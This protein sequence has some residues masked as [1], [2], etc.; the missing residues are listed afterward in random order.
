MSHRFSALLLYSVILLQCGI[1]FAQST[2][3]IGGDFNLL[4]THFSG[5]N[6]A[7][8]EFTANRV[9]SSYSKL[10]I[11]GTEDLGNGNSAIF[12]IQTNFRGDT[13]VAT[14]CGLECWVGL[15]GNWGV[16]KLG[17]MVPIYDD[18]S[19]PWYFTDTPGNHNPNAL[20]ANCGNG[21]GLQDG[22]MNNYLSRT[23]RYDSPKIH[24]VTLGVSYSMPP[25]EISSAK[26]NGKILVLGGKVEYGN[27]QLGFAH[28]R[29]SDVRDVQL[30]EQATT[31]SFALLNP[32]YFGLGYEHLRYTIASG[33]VVVRD[34]LGLMT[35]YSSGPHSFWLNHGIAQRGKGS[36]VRG[37]AVNTIVNMENSGATMTSLGYQ[38]KFSK[39]TQVYA[40]WNQV[41]NSENAR[42]SF[43]R[44]LA[45]S[46][47]VGSKLSVFALGMRFRF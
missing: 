40:F 31:I 7:G 3:S 10:M 37:S 9:D 21:S 47:A 39:T 6:T 44:A 38:Y 26:P 18:V 46:I 12:L 32:I 22:C 30:T 35:R 28:Q 4:T 42:Y 43:D 13:G 19:Y 24:G 25:N 36:S 41:D 8:Q 17:H 14:L 5:R 33:G 45:S 27:M 11:R 16:I 2:L 29:Q 34:Y 15:K 20:W 1:S 23:I